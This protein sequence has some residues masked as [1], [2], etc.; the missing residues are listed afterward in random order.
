MLYNK[1]FS[2]NY[3]RGKKFWS[4]LVANLK[5]PDSDFYSYLRFHCAPVNKEYVK[6][7][8]RQLNDDEEREILFDYVRKKKKRK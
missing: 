7:T 4:S 5:L 6:M 3:L 8:Y 1:K 2:L